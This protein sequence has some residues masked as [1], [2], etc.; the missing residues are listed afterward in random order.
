MKFK[1]LLSIFFLL[2]S[3]SFY[4]QG[5][6]L[7][8]K[9]EQLKSMK[10]A[11]ITSEVG[12]TSAEAEK[13]WPL[14]N[15]YDNKQ[16]ELRQR[17]LKAFQQRMDDG[18]INAMSDREASAFLTQMEKTEEELFELRQNFI[19]SLRGIIS[20]LKIIKLKK[21]EEDFNRKLLRQYRNKPRK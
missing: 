15:A 2:V 16:F 5:G 17:K 7:K 20:P 18:S 21:A 4:A 3:F 12:L 13:F 6:T 8:Q 9:K 10:T 1:T 14:Y 11:F 19:A